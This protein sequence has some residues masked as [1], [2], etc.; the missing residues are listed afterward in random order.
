MTRPQPHDDR[1]SE[2]DFDTA[3]GEVLKEFKDAKDARTREPD[4]PE[5][6]DP[7]DGEAGDALTPNEQAQEEATGG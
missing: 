4:R 2:P 6:D 1:S 5:E 3:L 7:H